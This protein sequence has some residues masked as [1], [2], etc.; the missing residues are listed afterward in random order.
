MGVGLK[1]LFEAGTQKVT[2]ALPSCE[3]KKINNF[4]HCYLIFCSKIIIFDCTFNV[5]HI[6]VDTNAIKIY[7]SNNN[8]SFADFH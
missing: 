7:L 8:F 3:F 1:N 2:Q 4:V 5:F 6:R